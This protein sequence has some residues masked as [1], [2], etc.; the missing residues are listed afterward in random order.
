LLAV[1]R[2]PRG[3][4]HLVLVVRTEEGD[5]VLDNLWPEIIVWSQM[6]FEW[7]QV[8]SLRN[9]QYWSTIKKQAAQT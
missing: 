1:V 4:G 5:L 9:P 3:K 6:G 2:T 7:L 8:Q